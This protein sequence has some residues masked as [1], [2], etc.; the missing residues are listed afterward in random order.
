L[1]LASDRRRPLIVGVTG[2][3]GSGKSALCRFLAA[4]GL[5]VVDADQVSR[6]VTAPGS[7]VLLALA[8]AFGPE[9]LDSHGALDRQALARVGLGDPESQARLH[10][11]LHPP[12][13]QALA[14]EV[15][16]LG[17]AG[18]EAV[19]IE[20]ALLLEGGEPEFYDLL[21]VVTASDA[22]KIARAEARGMPAAEARRR[23]ALQW[24][25]ERKAAAAH[26]VVRNDG[27]LVEL[28]AAA[29]RL[30]QVIRAAAELRN[31]EA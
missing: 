8:A 20:A 11:L 1:T 27:T 13:R 21:V 18:H 5:A 17:R 30:A 12:I 10:R 6:K 3:L 7:P 31:R 15:E 23:L 16:R 26:H 22:A 29:D 14:A 25:D 24:P 9:I 19:V 28:E 4:R 2:G